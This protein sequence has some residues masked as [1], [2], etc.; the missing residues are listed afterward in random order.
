MDESTVKFHSRPM[1]TH[2]LLPSERRFLAAMNEIVF[3]HFELLR[4]ERGE[5]LRDPWPKPLAR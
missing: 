2:D 1:W 5:L 4:I 3:G